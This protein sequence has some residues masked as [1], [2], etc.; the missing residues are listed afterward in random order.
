[1]SKYNLVLQFRW[2][3][4]DVSIIWN[5]QVFHV[6]PLPIAIDRHDYFIDA[7]SGNTDTGTLYASK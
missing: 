5:F 7:L 3:N 1:M 6:G 2:L 4:L